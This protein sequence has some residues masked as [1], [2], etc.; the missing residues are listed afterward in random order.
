MA[1]T[2]EAATETSGGS[3]GVAHIFAVQPHSAQRKQ[4]DLGRVRQLFQ[5]V[6]VVEVGILAERP[7]SHRPIHRSA[8]DIN[9]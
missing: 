6:C 4:F 5:P 8:I 3:N 1:A 9:V 7:Q 2:R